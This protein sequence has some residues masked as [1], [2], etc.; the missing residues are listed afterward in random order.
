MVGAIMGVDPSSLEASLPSKFKGKELSVCPRGPQ[1]KTGETSSGGASELWKPKFF[2]CE[3]CR[4]VTEVDSAKYLDT[5]VA[6]ARTIM[7]PNDVVALSIETSETLRS[8]LV[9]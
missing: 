7:L 9:I 5:S 1:K 6:L 2:A 3:L 4:Q 8:L